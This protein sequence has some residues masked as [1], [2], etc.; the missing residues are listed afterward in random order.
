MRMH[1]VICKPI[2]ISL[3]GLP[4]PLQPINDC[5]ELPNILTSD[6]YCTLLF[7]SPIDFTL[8]QLLNHCNRSTIATEELLNTLKSDAYCILLFAS[9]FDSWLPQLLNHCNRSTIAIEVLLNLSTSDASCILLFASP[10]DFLLSAPQPLQQ[11]N[12]CNSIYRH[13]MRIAYCYLVQV[14]RLISHCRRSSTTATT[15]QPLQLRSHPNSSRCDVFCATMF[16]G[17]LLV[18]RGV[19]FRA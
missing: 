18:A 1:F 7:V 3:T 13:P 17:H 10:F 5:K 14:P 15:D 12:H 4:Q 19:A 8:P 6:A 2:C 9:P 11:I 16:A